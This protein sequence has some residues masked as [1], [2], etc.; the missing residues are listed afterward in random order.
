MFPTE[1]D[2]DQV[3]MEKEEDY[4]DSNFISVNK[5]DI[6]HNDE[7]YQI[8]PLIKKLIQSNR[9]KGEFQNIE[10]RIMHNY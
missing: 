9:R 3:I 4:Y 7:D 8:Q 6:N 1:I 10:E 2:H 5:T